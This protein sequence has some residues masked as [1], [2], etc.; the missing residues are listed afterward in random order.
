LVR[1]IYDLR[2]VDVGSVI[3]MFWSRRLLRD[4]VFDLP[5]APLRPILIQTSSL[6]MEA[7]VNDGLKELGVDGAGLAYSDRVKVVRETEEEGEAVLDE[8]E[9]WRRRRCNPSLET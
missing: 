7:R 4:S 5:L 2:T 8:M 1:F 3:W 9:G 6:E